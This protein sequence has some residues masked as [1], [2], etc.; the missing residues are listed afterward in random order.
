MSK[1]GVFSLV[2]VLHLLEVFGQSAK[3][4]GG[5]SD[6]LKDVVIK[7]VPDPPVKG[8]GFSLSVQ[9]NLDKDWIV[10]GVDMDLDIVA[11]GI[12]KSKVSFKSPVTYM[13]GLPRG[14]VKINIGPTTLPSFPGSVSAKGRV[15]MTANNS[16]P[17][18]CIDLD[19]AIGS[20]GRDVAE[21]DANTTTS[22]LRSVES[23]TKASDHLK[24]FEIDVDTTADT[25]KVAGNLDEMLDTMKVN[26]DVVVE[27][28]FIKIPFK[29]TVPI[30]IS[31]QIPSGPFSVLVGP[32]EGKLAPD[33][34]V[35]IQGQVV[36]AD[37]K[38]E[39]VMCLKIDMVTTGGLIV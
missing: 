26:L 33:P 16:E 35:T 20:T 4:C 21:Q 22:P 8:Q 37:S 36:A 6:H 29:M 3:S 25:L 12:I 10:G 32:T 23:C 39:E 19:M 31:P 34:K 30:S 7:L 24:N 5:P 1:I 9:G 17:V 14:P 38:D 15:T 28:F 18:A 11:F 2:T 13:P 27:K